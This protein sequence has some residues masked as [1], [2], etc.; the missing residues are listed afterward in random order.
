[1]YEINSYKLMTIFV[2]IRLYS[3]TFCFFSFLSTVWPPNISVEDNNRNQIRFKK[4]VE[5][6]IIKN[7]FLTVLQAFNKLDEHVGQF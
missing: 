7:M 1:M 3:S 6:L 4:K 2:N 5:E